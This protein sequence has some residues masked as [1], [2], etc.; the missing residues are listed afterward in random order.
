MT[1]PVIEEPTVSAKDK[2]ESQ[3]LAARYNEFCKFRAI[4]YAKLMRKMVDAFGEDVLD[5]A[6]TIRRENGRYSGERSADVIAN[7]RKYNED[8]QILIREMD[9]N[10]H[11]LSAAWSRTCPCYYHANPEEGYHELFSL[12][13][14]YE[15][16]F[17]SVHEEKIGITWCCWDMGLTPTAHPLFC[18]YMPKHQLKGDNLCYQ[19]RRLASTPEEQAHL[20]SIEYTGWRSWK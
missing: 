12:W 8:P 5:I 10:W 16:A 1:V 3:E 4:V 14:I 17:K 18:Q 15:E 13:C 19:V 9:E 20:N 7:E 11:S 2:L 6:E